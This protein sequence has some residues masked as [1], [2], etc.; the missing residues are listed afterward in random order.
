MVADLAA[1]RDAG[2]AHLPELASEWSNR[3]RLPE[4]TVRT[5]LSQ[6]IHY[7]LDA[8]CL[9]GTARFYADAVACGLLPE[10]PDMTFIL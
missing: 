8:A 2:L 9:E 3:M 4:R 5:Y 1:S 10:S 7:R 6:N